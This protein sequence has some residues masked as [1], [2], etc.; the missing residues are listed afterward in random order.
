MLITGAGGSIG[1]EI[2]MQVCSF[3]PS[4]LVLFD[5]DE[6][7]L[8]NMSLRIGRILPHMID[9]CH[10]ATGDIRDESRLDEIFKAYTPEIV[11]HAAAYKHVPMMEANPKESIKVNIFG[12][13]A[14]AKASEHYSVSKNSY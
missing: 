11:F 6:T 1:S 12:T 10:F 5:I 14:M 2:V 8:H 3:D 4:E 7:E 13:Y 9:R